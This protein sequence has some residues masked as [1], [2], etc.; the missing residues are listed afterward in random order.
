MNTKT[1][2]L[3]KD[4]NTLTGNDLGVLVWYDDGSG[5]YRD[6]ESE[7]KWSWSVG[8]YVNG[9]LSN[10]IEDAVIKLSKYEVE[11]FEVINK[12]KGGAK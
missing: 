7:V 3:L 5:E 11:K 2:E 12:Y 1:F 9:L 8:E 4:Y 10:K 6:D